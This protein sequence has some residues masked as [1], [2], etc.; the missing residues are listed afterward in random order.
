MLYKEGNWTQKF[1]NGVNEEQ[2]A[3]ICEKHVDE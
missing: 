2:L 1:R 3:K